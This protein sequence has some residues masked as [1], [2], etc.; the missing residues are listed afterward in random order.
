MR[1]DAGERK[2]KSERAER[3]KEET[4]MG[5]ADRAAHQRLKINPCCVPQGPTPAE[6]Q[7]RMAEEKNKREKEERMR[8]A[9]YEHDQRRKLLEKIEWERRNRAA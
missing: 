2:G 4:R 6:V 8:Q 9:R 1:T 3:G 7:E 5:L